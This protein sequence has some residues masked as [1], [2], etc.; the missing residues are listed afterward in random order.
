M[1]YAL[2]AL[3]L[4]IG[5][6]QAN[7]ACFEDVGGTGCTNDSLFPE[8]NLRRLSCENLWYVRNSIY[9]DNGY[10][11]RTK[12]AQ[13]AFDNSDCYVRDQGQVKLNSYERQNVARIAKVERQKS[14]PR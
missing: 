13:A 7:A 11:F 9:D 4:L 2:L 6:S 3:A 12:R 14:C 1:R 8:A 10:C 5:P